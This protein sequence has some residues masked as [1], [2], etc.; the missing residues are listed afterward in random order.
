MDLGV[1][2]YAEGVALQERVR[3][4]R[5]AG[6]IPD[7][8]LLLRYSALTMN[9]HRIHYDRPYA[10]AV[11]AYPALVVHGPRIDPKPGAVGVWRAR[12][13]AAAWLTLHNSRPS[14]H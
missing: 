4:A 6:A 1:V 13:A 3:A 7:T 10:M 9:G 11:E 5:Q 12:T 14:R 2:P 8:V